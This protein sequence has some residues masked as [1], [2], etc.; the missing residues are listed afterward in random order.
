[1]PIT[2]A[3]L[4]GVTSFENLAKLFHDKLGWPEEEWKTF[5]GVKTVY[6]LDD[7]DLDDVHIAAVQK[8]SQDLTWGIFLLDFKRGFR[9]QALRR[10]LNAVA[11]RARERDANPKWQ[12]D[13]LLFICRYGGNA[14]TFA[15]FRGDTFANAKLRHFGWTDTLEARTAIENVNQLQWG[16]DWIDAFSVEKL[17]KAFFTRLSDLFYDACDAVAKVI[18]D[19]N[20]RRLFVQTLFNRLIFLRFV[21]K[22]GWLNIGDRPDYLRALWEKG[23]DGLN[24]FW[25]TRLNALFGAANHET[26]DKIHEISRPL[27]GEVEYLNG[28]LFDEDH[29]FAN[30]NIKIPDRIFEDLLG[31]NGLFYSY[32]FTVEESSPLDVQVAVDPEILGRIFEQLTISSKRHDTGSYYTPREIVQFMCREALVGYVAGKGIGED[33]ARKL[34]YELDD[35]ALS[36]Q[37]GNLTFEALKAIKVVDPACG[38]GAYL[39]GM[40]QE[41]YA[42]FEM[43]RRNDRKFSDNPAKEAHQRKLW[44]IENNIYGVDLQPFATNTAMLRLWLTLL[45][46]DSGSKPQPLPNLEYKIE[47]GDTLLGPDPLKAI[48]WSRIQ[49]GLD[50]DSI[51]ETVEDL[52]KLRAKYQD[53]HG[54]AKAIIKLELETKLRE[55]RQKATGNPDKEAST[56]DWRVEFFDVFL[57]DPKHRS[58]GFDVVIANPPY[59]DSEQMVARDAS[60]RSRV[61]ANFAVAKGNWDL[62]IPFWQRSIDLLNQDGTA[63]L[64]TPNKWLSIRYAQALRKMLSGHVHLIVDYTRFRVFKEVGVAAIVVS[65]RRSTPEE[66]RIRHYADDHILIFQSSLPAD[67][68]VQLE[69]WGVLLS[70]NLELVVQVLRSWKRVS[71]YCDLEEAATVGEAYELIPLLREQGSSTAGNFRLI[72]TGT[73]DPY[74]SLWG[75]K[76]TSYL[77][78]RYARPV[79]DRREYKERFPRRFQQMSSAKLI[80][81]GMRHFEAYW[82][83]K[84]D[85]IA[86]K[87]TVVA[88][89]FRNG[90]CGEL[91]LALLNSTFIKFLIKECYSSLAIDGGIN[92]T[93]NLVGSLPA[94][95][96]SDGDREALAALALKCQDVK[97]ANPD[98]DVSEFVVE[99]DKRVEFLYFHQHEAPTYDDWVAKREAEKGTVIEEIRNL[100]AIGHETDEFEC[101]SSFSWDIRKGEQA[102]YIKDEVHT[103]ICAML[104]AKGGDLLVGVDD[105]MNIIG[106]EQDL[107]RYGSK[108]KLVQ[109]LEGPLGQTLTPNPIGLV[110]IRPIDID[111]K[112]ILR[113]KVTP[114]NTE[115]Y[116]F[117][118]QIYVRRNSK[119]KPALSADEAAAWWPRRKNGDC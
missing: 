101:K 20:D 5:E 91:L 118:D 18:P 21:E 47:I 13:N 45:V 34:V 2:A 83:G 57:E 42:L 93:P 89:G 74:A 78:S 98:A 61:G 23:Q 24:P 71:D 66:V 68:T 1:M 25:P 41:L 28:G 119:S 62:Y 92:F 46:E 79:V 95:T 9:R 76:P 55:L 60:Y 12:S 26:S 108:D 7:P 32:N 115:R 54:H 8:L 104:N 111:G 4:Q 94:P 109:A 37:E 90:Y 87:S 113:I 29:R 114:D 67:L 96:V 99:I 81:S 52:R 105:D 70:Q 85:Y 33:K 64:V 27:I 69:D 107:A 6:G 110:Q 49:R 88:R 106:L 30:P 117:K 3:D 116:R 14:F 44:I 38:S 50:F 19:E 80:M 65:A 86:G 11:E 77:K 56:F 72:N 58:P 103:A 73:I 63:T 36:N 48:D 16:T 40:L 43:L 82:D 35:S 22:K 39:L 112:T 10:L 97:S 15:H 84:A 75:L 102:D 31:Q 59:V 51:G 53:S 100:V 17:T